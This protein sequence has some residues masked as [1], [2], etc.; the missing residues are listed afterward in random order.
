MSPPFQSIPQDKFGKVFWLSFAISIILM[1]A[2]NLAG[3]PTITP[4]APYGIIS[5]ERAGSILRSLE[6]LTSWDDYGRGSAAFSLGLDFLYMLAYSCTIALGCIWSS[7]VLRERDW[8]LADLGAPFAWGQWLAA[9]LDA[10]E[11]IALIVIL[12]GSV[13]SP[14]PE[15]AKWCALVKFALIFLGMAYAFFGLV[16]HLMQRFSS[17]F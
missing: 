15:L 2:L 14:W 13:V 10:V 11:N 3:G 5:Y 16:M 12:L 6:I 1:I 8:P 4:S 9:V 17:R 7:R